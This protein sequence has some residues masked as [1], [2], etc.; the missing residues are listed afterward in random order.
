MYII[1]DVL[2]KVLVLRMYII[3]V[4]YRIYY[5]NIIGMYFV[6]WL[7]ILKRTIEPNFWVQNSAETFITKQ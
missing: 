1:G 6:L 7:K 4:Q 2:L 5:K 3:Q